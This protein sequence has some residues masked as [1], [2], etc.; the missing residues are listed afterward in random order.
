MRK[1]TLFII[2][3]ILI[4]NVKINS[5]YTQQ[6]IDEN[7]SAN[8]IF[9][10]GDEAKY[11]Y[12]HLYADSDDFRVILKNG[13]RINYSLNSIFRIELY[14]IKNTSV[15]NPQ[16]DKRLFNKWANTYYFHLYIDEFQS[17][18]YELVDYPG[19][20]TYRYFIKAS[21]SSIFAEM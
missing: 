12:T 7:H 19:F 5:I 10:I 6:G 21:N 17:P 20:Y 18:D 11:R 1:F 16:W 3:I 8:Y 4:L 9:K 14:D 15:E 13:S 2:I